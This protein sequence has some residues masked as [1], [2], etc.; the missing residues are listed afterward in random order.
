MECPF[1]FVS[2]RTAHVSAPVLSEERTTFLGEV[3]ILLGQVSERMRLRDEKIFDLLDEN[4]E[5]RKKL[6]ALRVLLSTTTKEP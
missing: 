3:E 4:A 6:D 2:D 1:C 5:D